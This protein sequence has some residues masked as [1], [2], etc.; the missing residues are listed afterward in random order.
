MHIKSWLRRRKNNAKREE[1]WAYWPENEENGPSTM[2]IRGHRGR[3]ARDE[4]AGHYVGHISSFLLL[5]EF[6]QGA[7]NG[8]I[9][10]SPTDLKTD[11]QAQGYGEPPRPLL[12][13]DE[14]EQVEATIFRDILGE[15]LLAGEGGPPRQSSKGRKKS[16]ETRRSRSSSSSRSGEGSRRIVSLPPFLP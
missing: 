10:R 16:W 12:N 1:L 14:D 13:E 15:P 3:E 11:D 7:K 5:L 2:K 6:P 8:G 9:W 4:L